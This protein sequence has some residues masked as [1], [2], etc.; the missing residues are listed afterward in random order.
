MKHD[1]KLAGFDGAI[2]VEFV[3]LKILLAFR[4]L[5]KLGQQALHQ[6]QAALLMGV[7]QINPASHSNCTTWRS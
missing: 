1:L 4:A 2:A 3:V 5:A 6:G 7:E